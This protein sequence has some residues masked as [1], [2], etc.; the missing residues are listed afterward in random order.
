[1]TVT[2][3]NSNCV[4]FTVTFRNQSLPSSL[5]T[6]NFA[7]GV[8]D[9]G[10]VVTRTFSQVGT[11]NVTMNAKHPT[12]CTYT[13]EKNIVVRGPSG[14]IRYDNGFI[15]GNT[16]VRLEATVQDT[17]SIRW[18]LGDGT[19]ITTNTPVIYHVYKQSGLYVPIA[20]LLTN[21]LNNCSVL[22]KG[23]DT[24]KVDYLKAGFRHSSLSTCGNTSVQFTDTSRKYLPIVSWR[25][26]FGDGTFSTLQNP[27]KNYS[28]TNNWRIQLVV[29]SA[30]GC[31]DTITRNIFIKVNTTPSANIN[32]ASTAC[33]NRPVQFDAQ[34]VSADTVSIIN[35]SF[36]NGVVLTGTSV[37]NIYLNTGSYTTTLI[38]GTLYGCQDTV[39]KTI[40]INQ[41]PTITASADATICKG[42][43]KQLN[44]T[45]TT[46]YSWFPL[47]GSLSCTT[48]AN[49]IAKPLTTTQ[50][51]VTGTNNFGCTAVDS[52]IIKV[53][54]PITVSV[55]P[56]DTICIGQTASLSVSGATTY[57][58]S[59]AATLNNTSGQFVIATPTQT[60]RY[61]VIGFDNY[62][63]FQDTGYVTVA[64]GQYPLIQ[65]E[66]DKT[67]ATGT[68]L[69]LN[70][71]TT[72]GP[73]TSWRWTP[74]TNISCDD[75]ALPIA[76]VKNDICYTL[77]GAN[78]YKCANKDTICIK[79][80]CEN[81]QVFI[82]NTFTPD[83]DGINDIFMV[84][85]TGIKS[86]KSFR[87]FNRWGQ[88]IFERG[89]ITPNNPSQGWDGKVK[90]TVAL[91]DVYVYT[92]EVVCENNVTYT[93]KG[94]V[95]IIK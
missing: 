82:P 76:T 91:P 84:R 24:I 63:C 13:F 75:C 68:L 70:Y 17:D 27:T 54:Q 15:C 90:G 86:I 7:P 58:W 55:S 57:A 77:T 35:W 38:V 46:S 26:N 10:N 49:P 65:L 69:P 20:T 52:V 23:V 39:T 28:A 73:L 61:R 11:Y 48:C 22:I 93:Y 56:N 33:T 92:C 71:T 80:F 44:V 60:T 62:N 3:S 94:N 41:S 59:P 25:W 50:Y 5:T 79:V 19:I 9:T 95:A 18:N 66:N 74:N 12:G 8:N 14:S 64:V 47:D 51:I 87:I 83:N 43:T 6:W 81:T 40:I 37:N 31:S 32:A 88:V 89:N 53:A 72:N 4:P 29:T 2:D 1:F 16:P 34:Y 45:G 85:G 78:I 21:S 42:Q 67:L 36:T 30:S